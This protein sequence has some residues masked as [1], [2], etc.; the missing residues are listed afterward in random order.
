MEALDPLSKGAVGVREVG[1][2]EYIEQFFDAI[3]DDAPWHWRTWSCFTPAEVAG[4]DEVHRL[5]VAACDDTRG[6]QAQDAF[7]ASGWPD[8]IQ[9]A[10]GAALSLM[11]QRGRFSEEVEEDE[12]ST[13]E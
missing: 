5:L 8:R 6:S 10:A 7:I 4:L 1:V 9:P 11:T 3:S 12:P 13:G 2:A